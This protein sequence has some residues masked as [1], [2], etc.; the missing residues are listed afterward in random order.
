[1]SSEWFWCRFCDI[2][3]TDPYAPEKDGRIYGL[4]PG[5]ERMVNHPVNEV[6]A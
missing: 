3:F 4:C 1:M 6:P 2:E 5:C